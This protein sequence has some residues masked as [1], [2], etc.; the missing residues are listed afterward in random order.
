MREQT[1]RLAGTDAARLGVARCEIARL[2]EVISRQAADNHELRG[3]NTELRTQLA[4]AERQLRQLD[5]ALG[6]FI[7]I[8]G[9]EVAA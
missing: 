6:D 5:D 4:T 7:A 2:E 1:D 3:E 9:E 8:P